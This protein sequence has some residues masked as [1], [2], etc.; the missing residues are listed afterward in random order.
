MD[1]RT[2]KSG[3][4][5]WYEAPV[6]ASSLS[7]RRA[8]LDCVRVWGGCPVASCHSAYR[9]PHRRQ[10]EL[11]MKQRGSANTS[12]ARAIWG[13]RG[14]SHSL[15]LS[16]NTYRRFNVP[17]LVRRHRQAKAPTSGGRDGGAY[18]RGGNA[19]E[20]GCTIVVSAGTGRPGDGA[21]GV[22]TG[23]RSRTHRRESA[24]RRHRRHFAGTIFPF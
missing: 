8:G 15:R 12:S 23:D 17:P 3:G 24:M 7:P 22:G 5:Q 6:Y 13:R 19:H 20:Q 4:G 2:S 11:S 1:D 14:Y 10:A 18:G 16:R 9:P 21:T